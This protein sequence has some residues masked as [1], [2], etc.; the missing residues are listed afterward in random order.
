MNVTA[1]SYSN[2]SA[3]GIF[4]PLPARNDLAGNTE[5]SPIQPEIHEDLPD[6][7]IPQVEKS[8]D[9]NNTNNNSNPSE[10]G[11][12]SSAQKEKPDAAQSNIDP[13]FTESE[14]RLINELKLTDAEVKRH[15]MAHVAAGG[16]YIT[17]GANFSYRRGPD[18]KSYAVGGEVGIDTAPV[19]GDPS[20][21][22]Q[23]MRQIKSAALAPASP[24]AQDL[25]IA[26]QASAMATQALSE[27]MVEQA[28]DQAAKN[29]TQAFGNSQEAVD[30]YTKVNDLPEE[31]T[32]TIKIAV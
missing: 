28:K 32:S 9:P 27:L 18:G 5:Q 8:S 31:E 6:G 11:N 13:Q 21:T 17:S 10:D 26:S 19:P 14:L 1:I 3:G 30:S 29:E 20:A 23:K 12:Q 22:I 16:R 24:S 15:E 7:N 2:Y 25:K 4:N